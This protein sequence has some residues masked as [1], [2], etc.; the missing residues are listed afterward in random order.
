MQDKLLN[1]GAAFALDN[2]SFA[3]PGRVL[4]Q[5]LS[6]SFPQGKVCGLIG[7]NGSGKSTLLKL[8]G[9]HQAP[10]GGQVLLNRQPLAQWDGKSFARQVAYLPQQLP[11]A[12]GMT[13]REL[14]AV[15]RYPWHGALGRFGANDRQQVEEAIALVGLKPFANRLVDSL[16]GGERQRAWLA[17]MVAQDSRC[18]LLDEPTSALD[19]AHQ[20]EVLA[21]IQRLSRERDL[22]V[23]AVLHDINM[24]ARYC[25]H[26]VALRGG[27]MIA[28]GGPLEL[29]QGPVLEQIYGIPMGTLPHPSGGAPVSF[30]Y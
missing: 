4:L 16:S 19:I 8:L 7:H 14:V 6:L 9:R 24:A 29:M 22:T 3:V 5:P 28:Q 13:V 15:G 2:A 26:L 18:L 1:P 20:V 11:A 21:L 17:M 23:I 12:E 27:E 25:D 10:S 30:V